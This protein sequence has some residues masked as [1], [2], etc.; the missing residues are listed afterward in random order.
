MTGTERALFA[1]LDGRAQFVRVSGGTL[2][3][4]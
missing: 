2:E 3:D 4:G 1:G